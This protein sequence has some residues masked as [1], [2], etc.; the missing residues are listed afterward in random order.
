MNECIVN[1]EL[2]RAVCGM[3]GVAIETKKGG[4]EEF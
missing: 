1:L 3:L 4:T 2:A